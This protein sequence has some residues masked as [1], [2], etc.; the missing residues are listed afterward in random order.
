MAFEH[1]RPKPLT[2]ITSAWGHALVD[3]L[4]QLYDADR[5]LERKVDATRADLDCLA[6]DVRD[7]FDRL[8]GKIA[9][10]YM[11][12][13]GRVGVLLFELAQPALQ[14]LLGSTFNVDVLA[15]EASVSGEINTATESPPK[16]VL[17]PPPGKRIDTRSAYLASNSTSGEVWAY[18]KNSGKLVGKIYCSK[19]AMIPLDSIKLTGDVDEPIV[20]NWSGLDANSKIFYVIRYKL[21]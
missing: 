12:E 3:A 4:E 5:Q 15:T 11:D 21:L 10:L 1:L 16:V 2:A 8:Y 19:F 14:Q 18:F 13:Y 9:P 20:V 7:A 6:C 17:S